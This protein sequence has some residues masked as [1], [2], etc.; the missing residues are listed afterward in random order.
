MLDRKAPGASPKL[1]ADYQAALVQ[2]LEDCP[3]L[4]KHGVV[5]WRLQDLVSWSK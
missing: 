1:G 5:R 3:D 4:D 2:L